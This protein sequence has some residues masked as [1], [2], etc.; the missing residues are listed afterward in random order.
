MISRE[1]AYRIA[2]AWDEIAAAEKLLEE[3]IKALS[4]R[5]EPDIR[6]GFGRRQGGLQLGV[7][8]GENAHR[9]FD[10]QW[11]LARPVIE[12]HIGQQRAALRAL[13]EQA[14][15]ELEQAP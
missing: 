6:D 1:T 15:T 7:P 9:L 13:N 11:S 5:E 4:R 2:R 12:A 14:R 8:H 3:I 10:V